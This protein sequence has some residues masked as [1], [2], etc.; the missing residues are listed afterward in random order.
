MAHYRHVTLVNRTAHT[1]V[2]TWDGRQYALPP[3]A[4]SF[5]VN[6]AE[7]FKA[8]NPVMGSEDPRTGHIDYLIGIADYHDP[9]DPIEQTDAVEKW[10]R[11]KLPASAQNVEVVAGKNGLFSARDVQAQLP[12]DNGFVKP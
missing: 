12:V 11:S 10:D 7:K 6:M 4:S 3:G 9:I 1:L 8:Q 5:P 2:G